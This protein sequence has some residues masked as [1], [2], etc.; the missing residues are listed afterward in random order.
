MGSATLRTWDEGELQRRRLPGWPGGVGTLGGPPFGRSASASCHCQTSASATHAPQHAGPPTR[1]IFPPFS[2]LPSRQP[3]SL[4]NGRQP[5]EGRA[6]LRAGAEPRSP[7]PLFVAT[8][9]RRLPSYPIGREG[10]LCSTGGKS[11]SADWSVYSGGG[12]GVFK[13]PASAVAKQ[14][15]FD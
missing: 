7:R 6:G 3:T 5:G 9:W 14:Q 10:V 15:G 4:T 8:G 12:A 1:G 11:L 13:I 2:S